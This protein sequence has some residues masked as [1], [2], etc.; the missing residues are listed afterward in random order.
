MSL[1]KELLAVC[2]WCEKEDDILMYR[3]QAGLWWKATPKQRECFKV[4][5]TFTHSICPDHYKREL[6]NLDKLRELDGDTGYN[7]MD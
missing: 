4:D 7:A 2:A 3:T 5:Y 6:T 1:E